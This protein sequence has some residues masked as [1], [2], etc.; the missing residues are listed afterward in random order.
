MQRKIDPYF[1]LFALV[2][3][4]CIDPPYAS[5]AGALAR[6]VHVDASQIEFSF[7]IDDLAMCDSTQGPFC[8]P[9]LSVS[10]AP[11]SM[12]YTPESLHDSLGIPKEVAISM[13][14]SQ[15]K[16]VYIDQLRFFQSVRVSPSPS[17]V[18]LSDHALESSILPDGTRISWLGAWSSS[19]TR[20]AFRPDLVSNSASLKF[21]R[22]VVVQNLQIAPSQAPIYAVGYL[23]GREQWRRQV[24]Y[25]GTSLLGAQVFAR[26]RGNGSIYRATVMFDEGPEGL[27]VSWKDGDQSFRSIDRKDVVSVIQ[28]DQQSVKSID[29]II[30]VSAHSGH[31]EELI[32]SVGPEADI[33]IVRTGGGLVFEDQVSAGSILYTARELI[34]QRLRVKDGGMGSSLAQALTF[35]RGS[36][37]DNP[38]IS[39]RTFA[40]FMM[41]KKGG[42]YLAANFHKK[43]TAEIVSKFLNIDDMFNAF[44]DNG[45][46]RDA[47]V[48]SLGLQGVIASGNWGREGKELVLSTGDAFEGTMTCSADR[49]SVLRLDV[50]ETKRESYLV[51]G[52]KLLVSRGTHK[53]HVQA[54][55]HHGTSTL[56][57]PTVSGWT[58][59]LSL[60]LARVDTLSLVE[61]IGSPTNV[62]CGGLVLEP[63]SLSAASRSA[64]ESASP[65]EWINEV[66]KSIAKFNAVLKTLTLT[67]P[68]TSAGSA[69]LWVV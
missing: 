63:T 38:R 61:L 1:L 17:S 57:V 56:T 35:K 34:Q 40:S 13:A 11:N 21:S 31:V 7:V 19:G 60:V 46:M 49:E 6:L 54:A 30:F 18:Y 42:K 48:M 32:V 4:L 50:V 69:N 3:S 2:N 67:V 25:P 10:G 64:A 27:F 36:A 8:Q 62:G 59:R 15:R 52:V 9:I 26:W 37:N 23:R 16:D 12:F 43:I 39:I 65:A 33:S 14:G 51:S 29:E 28:G 22:P 66:E 53:Y 41:S 68:A 44:L 58:Y 47:T 55:F 24:W 5:F 45:N 20:M